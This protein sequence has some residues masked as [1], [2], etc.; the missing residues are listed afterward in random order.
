MPEEAE[1]LRFGAAG[2]VVVVVSLSTQTVLW[3]RA[4]AAVACLKADKAAGRLAVAVGVTLVFHR[5]SM[6]QT[7]ASYYYWIGNCDNNTPLNSVAMSAA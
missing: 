1:A 3:M 6:I 4:A 2:V 7:Q 5:D